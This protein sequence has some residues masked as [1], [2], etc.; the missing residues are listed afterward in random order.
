M[1][2][3]LVKIIANES[4]YRYGFRDGIFYNRASHY[5]IG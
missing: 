1:N 5:Y 4:K 2:P 3:T